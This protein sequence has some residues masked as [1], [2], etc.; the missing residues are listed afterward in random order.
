[1]K[2]MR[3]LLLLVVVTLGWSAGLEAQVPFVCDGRFYVT[4]VNFS[5]SRFV[6]VEIDPETDLVDFNT[7]RTDL[8]VIIN[9]IGYR[10]EENLI[11][12]VHPSEHFLYQV[13]AEGTVTV[14]ADLPLTPGNFYLGADITPDGQYLMLVGSVDIEGIPLDEE[15]IR[16]DLSDPTYPVS[17]ILLTGEPVN[18]LDIAFD[19]TNDVLYGFDSF[20]DRLVTVGLDGAVVT[21]FEPSTLLENAGSVFFDIFGNL[22]AYGSPAGTTLQNTLYAVNKETGEFRI[23]TTGET[24]RATD[25]CSCPHSVEIQKTVSPE[26]TIPCG[27]VEYTFAI[28]NQSR[29]PQEGID[30]QDLLPA[31]FTI[32]QILR[33]PFGGTVQSGAGTGMLEITDMTIPPGI[34]SLIIEVEVG[35]I[36]GGVYKNQAQLFGLPVGLGEYRISDDPRTLRQHDSTELIVNRIDFDTLHLEALYCVGEAVELDAS[37]YGISFAWSTGST[38]PSLLVDAVGTYS[39]MAQS[40]C[41]TALIVFEVSQSMIDVSVAA[42]RINILIGDTISLFSD[43]TQ[44][45]SSVVYDWDDPESNSLDCDACPMPLAFPLADIT[46]SLQVTDEVGCTDLASISINVDSENRIF[47]PN[48]FSPNGDQVNDIFYLQGKGVMEI[49]TWS[50]FDRFG[51]TVHAVRGASLNDPL[52]GW[53]GMVRDRYVLPGVYVWVAELL[54]F[55]GTSTVVS[56]DVTVMR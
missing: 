42:E 56:G 54:F 50:I 51:N 26:V 8:G 49:A 48:V 3:T 9:G 30:L 40:P 28:A 35:D 36:P 7:I 47:A 34:D 14:L 1:M 13:D 32:T 15:L 53:N 19:P 11:Y 4:M 5:G 20:G 18:M 44:S 24:A 43:V 33:N 52:A 46:Y 37:A 25:G 16:V 45:G 55:D 6:V 27:F 22:Y 23:L 39:V 17:R 12:G 29:R 41:D 38:A 31:G 21:D 2:E 10:P